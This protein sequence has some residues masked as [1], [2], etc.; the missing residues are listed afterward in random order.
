M[1]A[2]LRGCARS[3][4]AMWIAVPLSRHDQMH[5]FATPN[6]HPLMF[7]SDLGGNGVVRAIISECAGAHFW[8]QTKALL[9]ECKNTV[10]R[11][12]LCRD[13][14]AGAE[15]RRLLYRR[16]RAGGTGRGLLA[17]RRH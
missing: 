17:W 10:E 7:L 6:R 4:T 13:L 15:R 16:C 5:S 11:I 9:T 8:A 3:R 12:L 2:G 14:E 1:N